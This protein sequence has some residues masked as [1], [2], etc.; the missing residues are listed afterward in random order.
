ME[1]IRGFK[2]L[3]EVERTFMAGKH[4]EL[5][6]ETLCFQA[7]NPGPIEYRRG[8]TYGGTLAASIKTPRELNS[9]EEKREK[10][11]RYQREYY[12]KWRG[13]PKALRQLP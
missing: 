5:K 13:V 2:P 3:T 6:R 8:R 1:L 10:L 11:R 12:R 9:S 4:L 7:L